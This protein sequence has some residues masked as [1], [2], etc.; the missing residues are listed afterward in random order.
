MTATIP[1]Q[2]AAAPPTPPATR[3]A[4]LGLGLGNTLEWY[5]WMIFGLLSSVIGPHFFPSADPVA[6]TLSALAVFAVG[7]AVR[8]LGGVILGTVADRIGRRKVMLLSVG[9][10]AGTT[11]II[12]LTP[13]YASIGVWAGVI[14]LVC[15]LVQGVSTGI[16]APL[17][18]AYA[19]ELSPK[20]REGRAAGYISFF[21]NFGILLASVASFV[22]SLVIGDEAMKEWGWRLPFAFGALMGVFVLYLRRNLSE[23][24]HEEERAET[25]AGSVWRGVGRHWLGL[26]AI[27]FVVG[28]AQAYNYA[29]N[30]GLPSMAGGSFGEN[31]TMIF[32]AT[33]A[34]GV[35]LL[36][37]SVVTGIIADRAKLS[38]TFLVTRL[39]AVPSVFLM[40]LYDEPGFGGFMAVLLGGSL[41]LVLN[42]TLY[43]VV[44]T[45]LMPKNC[46]GTGCALGY[47]IA[48]AAFGG[49]ASYLMVWLQEQGALWLFP[50][51]TAALS[52]ISVVLY[53]AA[54]RS[55]G[56]YA[57]E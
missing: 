23:T 36:V 19:V 8:P 13:T 40:L 30:V 33:T 47:G 56:T 18:T 10:M 11:L 35:V 54:R 1:A 24:L 53:V 27:I 48:V 39:L 41:V 14:L 28:A 42:M 4:M 17:S 6:S 31:P 5:D 7:F 21:V 22:T 29:W 16:E 45:S 25:T 52:V 32:G 2:R 20:G 38:R 51:Y 12:A 46:R 43:N 34:L 57:G 50:A 44:S 55:T 3:K 49:T 9:L 37:G 15:R 26:L